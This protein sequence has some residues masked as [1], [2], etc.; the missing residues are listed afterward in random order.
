MFISCI[1]CP[2][3]LRNIAVVGVYCTTVFGEHSGQKFNIN[4]IDSFPLPFLNFCHGDWLCKGRKSIILYIRLPNGTTLCT[5]DLVGSKNI[6]GVM[7]YSVRSI[8]STLRFGRNCLLFCISKQSA[9]TVLRCFFHFDC[10][11]SLQNYEIF[12][13][14]WVQQHSTKD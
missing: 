12:P 1:T 6:D 7:I 14:L 3:N 2:Q 13:S 9:E 4:A 8:V 5:S 10:E 11:K